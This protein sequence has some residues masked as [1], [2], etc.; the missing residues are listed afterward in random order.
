MLPKIRLQVGLLFLG[1]TLCIYGLFLM[2]ARYYKEEDPEYVESAFHGMSALNKSAGY[3]P[4]ILGIG[5]IAL[6]GAYLRREK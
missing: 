3:G 6:A 2:S 5:S 1:C 4:W